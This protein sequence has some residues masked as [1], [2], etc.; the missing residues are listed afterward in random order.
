MNKYILFTFLVSHS[1]AMIGSDS[2]KNSITP[3]FM[4]NEQMADLHDPFPVSPDMEKYLD[5]VE[6]N[7]AYG[8]G[9]LK[10]KDRGMQ[11]LGTAG[12]IVGIYGTLK[13]IFGVSK[14]VY[15]SYGS[16]VAVINNGSCV[17]NNVS[18]AMC[19]EQLGRANAILLKE[20]EKLVEWRHQ[21]EDKIIA[22]H[23]EAEEA[24]RSWLQKEW[25][26]IK[27]NEELFN[28][29]NAFDSLSFAQLQMLAATE[30]IDGS[31]KYFFKQMLETRAV[32]LKKEIVDNQSDTVKFVLANSNKTNNNNNNSVSDKRKSISPRNSLSL[33]NKSNV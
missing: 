27:E 18:K 11:V 16:T 3:E 6:K 28:A 32:K 25:Q 7:D 4:S 23:K 33:E 2:S 29:K 19:D 31:G 24:R 15:D 26:V 1:I 8:D 13:S 14:Y 9:I 12:A 22:H 17:A 5:F 21:E 30:S 10:K 20:K